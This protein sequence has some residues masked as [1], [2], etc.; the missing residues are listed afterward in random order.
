M[1]DQEDCVI[2]TLQHPDHG[3]R[4]YD[5]KDNKRRVYYKLSR[6]KDYF[7]KVIVAFD[8]ADCNGTGRIVTAY[9]PDNIKPGEKPELSL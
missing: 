8:D 1:E 7:I 3:I 5:T 9:M 6:S 4:H 2:E